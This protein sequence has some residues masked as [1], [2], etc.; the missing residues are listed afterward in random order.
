[1]WIQPQQYTKK[2]LGL[3][4]IAFTVKPH[5]PRPPSVTLPMISR[6]Q[7]VTLK[8]NDRQ[9]WLL[10]SSLA[11]LAGMPKAAELERRIPYHPS[12]LR[13]EVQM[14]KMGALGNIWMTQID[15]PLLHSG[16][17]TASQRAFKAPQRAFMA[18][19]RAFMAPHRAFMAQNRAFMA[20]H[21]LSRFH[22]ELSWL[23]RELSWLHRELS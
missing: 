2:G 13:T 17:F 23:H 21:D 3:L 14:E 19:Q 6:F 18:L 20:L 15:I 12:I 8:Q 22:R 16:A 5:F 9:T 7:Q 10:S 1:V 4:A 11:S